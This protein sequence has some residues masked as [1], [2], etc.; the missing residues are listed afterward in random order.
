MASA[1]ISRGNAV[2]IQIFSPTEFRKWLP[3]QPVSDQRWIK[4]NQF[5]A[6]PGSHLSLPGR[7]GVLKT[8]L[9]GARPDEPLYQLAGLQKALPRGNYQLLTELDQQ[10]TE[11]AYLGWGLAAYRFRRYK[12]VPLPKARL[13]LPKEIKDRVDALLE[14]QNL[15]RDLINTPTED[16]GPAELVEAVRLQAGEYAASM[17]VFT[18][19]DLLDHNFPAVHAVGRASDSPPALIHLRWGDEGHPR[20]ALVGKG[21]CFDSGG[22]DIKSAAGMLKMKKDM[23]GAAHALALARLVMALELPVRLDLI[24]PAVENSISGNAYRPGDV[25]STRQ[26]LTVEIGNT[27]AE[28]R[29]ILSDGL[30]LACEQ[31]PDLIIDFA[32]LTGAARV[33]LGTDLPALFTNSREVSAGLYQAGERVSDPVWPMPLYQPYKKLLAS[34]IADLSNISKS[35]FGGAITAAL[36]LEH[37]VARDIPWVHLD[38][39]AWSDSDKP[40]RPA[41]GEAMGLRAVFDFLSRRYRQG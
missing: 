21:V 11:L 23:G 8:V 26:G 2:P 13:L 19:D 31:Q 39:Y 27:D 16:F 18:G 9:L 14:A 29:I 33:A 6:R 10:Q 5:S 20:L 15:V 3:S 28:G 30:T 22:L 24:I 1:F 36:F 40:A 4:T 38:T 35:S 7:G 41:G 32:T 37:F 25:I 34:K 12:K 17:E